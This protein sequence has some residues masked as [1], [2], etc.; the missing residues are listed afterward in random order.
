[1]FSL[2]S[3]FGISTRVLDMGPFLAGSCLLDRAYSILASKIGKN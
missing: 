2:F 1:M 3:R